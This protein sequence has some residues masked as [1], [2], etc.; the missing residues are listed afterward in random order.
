MTY[1]HPWLGQATA[2]TVDPDGLALTTST[3][4]EQP[5]AAGWLRRLTRTLPAG[6][7]AVAPATAKT[8]STYYGDLENAPAV[9]GIPSGTKQYGMAKSTTGPTPA[10]GGAITTEYAY[11]AW[12]R[13]VATKST[14][15]T[16]WS[17]TGYDARGKVVSSKI[18][19]GS[20]VATISSSTT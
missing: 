2:G 11:D 19:G 6:G 8:T 20:G 15:D 18:V 12:G 16:D 14:G 4:F 5:G 1:Q 13:A 9:C 10:S 3:T 7:V 17:C